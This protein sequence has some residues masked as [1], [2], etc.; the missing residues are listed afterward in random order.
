M[1]YCI[2][3]GRKLNDGEVCNCQAQAPKTEFQATQGNNF[4][5]ANV[6]GGATQT[7]DSRKKITKLL[8]IIGSAVMAIACFMPFYTILSETINYVGGGTGQTGDGVIVVILAIVAI[9][10]AVLNLQKFGVIP[11]AIAL[12]ITIYDISQVSSASMGF[13]SFGIG[14]YLAVIGAIVAIVGGILGFVWKLTRK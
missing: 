7:V 4:Q 14:A 1:S 10:L 11:A 5:T 2:K 3:C 13:G 6:T 8:T 12:V 9:V